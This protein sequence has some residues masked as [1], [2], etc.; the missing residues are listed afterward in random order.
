MGKLKMVVA[1]ST[2]D[3]L[4]SINAQI[5][6]LETRAKELKAQIIASGQEEVSGE[7][8]GAKIVAQFRENL[9]MAAVRE[10][11]S[12]QFISA[13]TTV[14]EVVSV[15]VTQRKFAAIESVP[16]KAD[17]FKLTLASLN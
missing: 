15:R 9:D 2:V 14:K 11:L 6:E 4:G 16:G 12:P 3:E 7:F 5:A 17:H 10:K 13:H 1:S 8:Y